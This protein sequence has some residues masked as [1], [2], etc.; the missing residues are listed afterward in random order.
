MLLSNAPNISYVQHVLCFIENIHY[1]Q[2]YALLYLLSHT[3]CI[4][5]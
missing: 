2:N 4:L 5:V 1:F 3:D